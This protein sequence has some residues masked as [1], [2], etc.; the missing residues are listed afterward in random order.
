MENESDS[1]SSSSSEN[2]AEMKYLEKFSRRFDHSLS[3]SES[4]DSDSHE[5][6]Y[7]NQSKIKFMKNMHVP[8]KFPSSQGINKTGSLKVS[9]PRSALKENLAAKKEMQYLEKLEKQ[10]TRARLRNMKPGE[11]VKSIKVVIDS[12]LIVHDV[13][14]EFIKNELKEFGVDLTLKEQPIANAITWTKAETALADEGEC[15]NYVIIIWSNQKFSNVVSNNLLSDEI[16]QI[17]RSFENKKITLI[18]YLG[19]DFDT[20]SEKWASHGGARKKK[21]ALSK[22]KMEM[23]L[24]RLQF[25][26]DCSYRLMNTKAELAKF[27]TQFTKSISEIPYRREKQRQEQQLAWLASADSRGCVRVDKASNGLSQLWKQQLLQFNNCN[28]HAVDEITRRYPTPQALV[29]AYKRCSSEQEA[30]TLL[31]DIPIVR[32]CIGDLAARR[33]IGPELS[34]KLHRLFTSKNPNVQLSNE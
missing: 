22:D 30:A 25:E 3:D 33:K 16:Q 15:E 31:K 21:T 20:G 32:K 17:K 11:C 28:L 34:R 5:D 29:K 12:N 14:F 7:P 27:I 9:I 10:A 6:G 1:S 24:V 23:E 18:I 19:S 13:V 4:S 8:N 2:S 26:L